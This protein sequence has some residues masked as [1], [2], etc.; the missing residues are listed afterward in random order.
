MSRN[1]RGE[2]GRRDAHHAFQDATGAIAGQ[3]PRKAPIPIGPS[4]FLYAQP[5]FRTV[6]KKFATA[7]LGLKSRGFERRAL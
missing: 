4:T 7:I 2:R 6:C 1:F 5:S 3:N